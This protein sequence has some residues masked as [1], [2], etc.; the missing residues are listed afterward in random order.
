LLVICSA[1]ELR[2]KSLSAT[3]Y[4]QHSDVKAVGNKASKFR[5]NYDFWRNMSWPVVI[6]YQLYNKY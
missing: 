6:A 4:A 5:L 3:A 2:I 1:E